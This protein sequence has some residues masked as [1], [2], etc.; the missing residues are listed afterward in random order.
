MADNGRQKALE[1]TLTTL[2]K[3]FG[4]GVVMKLGETSQLQIDFYWQSELRY[5]ARDWWRSPGTYY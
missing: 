3:R 1:T 2:N 4:D 5:C